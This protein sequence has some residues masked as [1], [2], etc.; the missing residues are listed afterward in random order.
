MSEDVNPGLRA[1][2]PDA[3]F[4]TYFLLPFWGEGVPDGSCWK[5]VAISKAEFLKGP[6]K[7]A[8]F[9]YFHPHVREFLYHFSHEAGANARSGISYYTLAEHG[10]GSWRID[11]DQNSIVARIP[12]NGIGLY[13]FYNGLNIICV[14]ACGSGNIKD[15]LDF[16]NLARRIFPVFGEIRLQLNSGELPAGVD[17]NHPAVPVEFQCINE[18]YNWEAVKGPGTDINPEDFVERELFEARTFHPAMHY[19]MKK[20][21]PAGRL[22]LI[23]CLS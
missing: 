9:I 4:K 5:Q 20:A 22:R 19:L 18:E 3:V 17:F 15:A 1:D 8:E 16:N 14:E 13:R 11:T 2:R 6:R 21:S 23:E 12:E 10:A 7:C